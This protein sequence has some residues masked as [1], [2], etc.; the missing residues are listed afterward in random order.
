MRQ[1]WKRGLTLD[2]YHALAERQDFCCAICGEEL[3]SKARSAIDHC[4][5][6]HRVRGLLC[7]NCNLGLG[8]FAD[9]Q[10]RLASAGRYLA[11]TAPVSRTYAG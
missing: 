4:H 1:L 6:S 3:D 9:S 11:K 10:A 8:H 5:N 7:I 2:Q